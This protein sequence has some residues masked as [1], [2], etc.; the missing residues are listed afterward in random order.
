MEI[1]PFTIDVPEAEVRDLQARLA[2]ARWPTDVATDWSRGTPVSYAQGLA[3]RWANQFDWRA[4]EQH[5]NAFPQFIANVDGQPIHFVHVRSAVPDATP[6][7][8]AHGYP[9][10]FVEFTRMIG[11]LVDP[12]AHGGRPDDAFHVVIP[13]LPGFGFS[14]PVTRPGLGIKGAAAAFDAIMLALGYERYGVHGGDVGAGI[15]EELS[16]L[17]GARITWSLGSTAPAAIATAYTPPTAHPPTSAT[18]VCST[19]P[20]PTTIASN[21]VRTCRM[22]K[23][24]RPSPV[25]AEDAP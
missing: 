19:R 16:I 10:S 18:I 23:D 8:L 2:N 5:L 9:S 4:A 20:P 1:S 7:L 6:L 3:E 13:S 25:I 11:P 12:E 24:S 22:P 21:P 17:A 14:T 15:A